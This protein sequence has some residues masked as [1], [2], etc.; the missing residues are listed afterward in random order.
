MLF[1]VLYVRFLRPVPHKQP[2]SSDSSPDSSLMANKV[3][4]LCFDFLIL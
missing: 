3:I 4:S 1:I 2:S